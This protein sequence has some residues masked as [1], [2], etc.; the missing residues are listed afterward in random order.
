MSVATKSKAKAQLLSQKSASDF[1]ETAIYWCSQCNAPIAAIEVPTCPKCGQKGKYLTTDVRPVFARERRILQF[2]HPQVNIFND[3]VWKSSK[4]KNYFVNGKSFSLPAAEEVK[5][6]L[7]AIAVY[8]NEYEPEYYDEIDK[9][10]II[11]AFRVALE[12]NRLHLASL[13]DDAFDF[14][15]KANQ[16]YSRRMQMVSFSG[17]KDST[18][19][20][21]LVRRVLGSS[22]TH[23]FSDTTLEDENTYQYIQDF[24]SENPEVPF[25]TATDMEAFFHHSRGL[26][27]GAFLASLYIKSV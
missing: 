8:I 17:G 23:V 1:S 25:W 13:E 26:M 27:Q 22:V 11:P 12:V 5:N 24:Q 14:I 4:A 18:V 21:H 2:Y 15:Q 7:S 19:V 16:R 9:L 10:A 20:S 3:A 6:D